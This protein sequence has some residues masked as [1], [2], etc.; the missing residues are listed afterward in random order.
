M[1]ACHV[2]FFQKQM[3]LVKGILWTLISGHWHDCLY[4]WS[5][6]LLSLPGCVSKVWETESKKIDRLPQTNSSHL[7]MDGWN[8]RFLLGWPIFRGYVS[9]REGNRFLKTGRI[10][11]GA[12]SMAKIVKKT[13]GQQV[14][15]ILIMFTYVYT[16]AH[17]TWW[18]RNWNCD[19][20]KL[21]KN[22]IKMF[23]LLNSAV[24]E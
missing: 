5:S 15:C 16:R 17:S 13:T 22:T 1:L 23:V 14:L 2:L 7:K 11:N 20:Y 19:F 12:R 3:S 18:Y 4:S 10:V 8:T 6:W 24:V 9:F 21:K